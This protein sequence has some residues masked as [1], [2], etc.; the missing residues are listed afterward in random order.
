[1]KADQEIQH[2]LLPFGECHRAP[3]GTSSLGE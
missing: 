3:P 2:L 1:V